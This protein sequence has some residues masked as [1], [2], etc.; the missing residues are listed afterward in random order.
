MSAFRTVSRRR[1]VGLA[2]GQLGDALRLAG[3]V[4]TEAEVAQYRAEADPGGTGRIGAD[5]FVALAAKARLELGSGEDGEASADSDFKRLR[6]ALAVF[7]KQSTGRIN[8]G[9]LRHWLT[10]LGE[11]IDE[12]DVNRMLE[13]L[14]DDR[15]CWTVP[16]WHT[17]WWDLDSVPESPLG[18]DV[19]KTLCT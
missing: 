6:A 8:A 10:S 1:G 4:V 14:V 17:G 12:A 19:K 13:H 16:N 18:F 2:V 11:P 15:A 3:F 7:D 5:A 9:D